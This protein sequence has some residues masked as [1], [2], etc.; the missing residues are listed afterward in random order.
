MPAT[1]H[2]LGTGRKGASRRRKFLA[3]FIYYWWWQEAS[4]IFFY[5]IFYFFHFKELLKQTAKNSREKHES[6]ALITHLILQS[7]QTVRAQ[8]A[9]EVQSSAEC[10]RVR[11]R[12]GGKKEQT[13]EFHRFSR[14]DPL[15]IQVPLQLQF[16]CSVNFI[17]REWCAFYFLGLDTA[18]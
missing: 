12:E 4:R 8:F 13:P 18:R 7:N 17:F 1:P 10:E 2:S 16:S 5:F 11:G 9:S 14:V 3:H 15:H 6:S